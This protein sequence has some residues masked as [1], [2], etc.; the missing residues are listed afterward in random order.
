MENREEIDERVPHCVAT[1]D[2][3]LS[4]A[5]REVESG[6]LNACDSSAYMVSHRSVEYRYSSHITAR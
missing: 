3:S 2:M 1:T 6:A 5:V 4:E